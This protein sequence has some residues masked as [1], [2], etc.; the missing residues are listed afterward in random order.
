MQVEKNIAFFIKKHFPAIYRENGGE[1]V[2]LVEDYY[3]FLEEDTRQSNYNVRRIF[4]YRDIATT[5]SSMIIFFK[6]KFLSDLP[7]DDATVQFAVRNILD[8]YRRKGTKEGLILFFRLFYQEDVEIYYPAEQMLRPS[9]S[10]WRTGN[11]LEMFAN[12]G[13]FTDI[14]GNEFTYNDLIGKNITGSISK[15]KAAVSVIN[16]II[17]NGA[18][19]PIIYIDEVQGTFQ[20]YDDVI[21]KI[22]E[23]IVSFGRVSGS[24]SK[25]TVDDPA[26]EVGVTVGSIFDVKSGNG[27]AGKGLVTKVSSNPTGQVTYE[28]DDGGWGYTA[29]TSTLIVS[30]QSIIL[31]NDPFAF[32]VGERLRD[33]ESNFAEVIGQNRGSVGVLPDPGDTFIFGRRIYRVSNGQEIVNIFDVTPINTSSPGNMFADTGL[34]SDVRVSQL[35]NTETIS[36]ITDVISDYVGVTINDS[37][38][39]T[40]GVQ[41]MSGTADPVTLATPLNQAFNL[42]PIT[43]GTIKGISNINPG[44]DYINDV[45]ALAKDERIINFDRHNQYIE[46]TPPAIAG[47]FS[48]N[49]II[50]EKNTNKTARVLSTDIDRGLVYVL[51]YSY[52]GF[53]GDENI[54]FAGDEFEVVSVYTDYSSTNLGDNAVIDPKTEFAEGRIQE[55]DIYSSGYGYTDETR[56]TLVNSDGQIMVEGIIEVKEQGTTSGYWSDFSSHI[57][58]YQTD[59]ENVTTYYDS[60]MKIQDNDFYQE[61]SYQIKSQLGLAEY[62]SFVKE[63]MHLAGTK[64]F[65]EFYYRYKNNS[66]IQPRFVRFFNDDGRSSALD[67]Y[68]ANNVSSDVTNLYSDNTFITC[69]NQ[70]GGNDGS[71][72]F[73]YSITPAANDVDE[74]SNLTFSVSVPGW[75]NGTALYWRVGPGTARDAD[76]QFQ[77]G[78]IVM[79]NGSGS[80]TVNP[81]A[82]SSTEGDETFNVTLRTGSGSGTVVYTSANYTINDT[83]TGGV[84]FTPDYT[85]NVTTPIFDYV[86]N[87]DHR[88]GA[89]SNGAQPPLTFNAGDNVEFRIDSGTQSSHPFYLKT[90]QGSG[91]ANQVPNVTGQGGAVLQW[92]AVTGTY[93]YQCANHGSMN[94][95]ITVT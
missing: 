82:D 63:N 8:L 83:S 58:G 59:Q 16:T 90:V 66:Q 49:D 21:C 36:L 92:T 15:A 86:L 41:P 35:D 6:N 88:G 33:E 14:D 20:K 95:T 54:L 40:A 76:F 24:L 38:Y 93:Y 32:T 11:Y 39:N 29:N 5:A 53:S 25:F 43:I 46:V 34:L 73:T 64:L 10:K 4:E 18:Q 80:F 30:S 12:D 51:P 48:L 85:I 50:T 2:Q 31:D 89:L 7:F 79:N 37:N 19:S 27:I 52:Y 72:G 62:E 42:T 68:D 65:G 26:G 70:T 69:D 22:G 78:N 91:T 77:S 47:T 57:N 81:I 56:A 45:F 94:N 44:S 71:G 55:V 13:K 74:G 3:R 87:G 84:S 17:L 75:P 9:N 60:N 28:I 67:Q 23:N 1:L 61:Y